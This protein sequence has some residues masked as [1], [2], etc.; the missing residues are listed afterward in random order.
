MVSINRH[1][2]G[3]FLAGWT[4]MAFAETTASSPNTHW[5]YIAP[6]RPDA[7]ETSH[8]DW[9]Q[10]PIDHFILARLDA[11]GLQPSPATD[12]ATW[13]RRVSLDLI[14]LPPTI[15]QL[16]TFLAD[17]SLNARERV[18]DRLLKS[19]QFGEHWA[20][21]WLDLARYGDSTGVHE[22]H[23]RPSWA[24]R[25]WVINALNAD[26]PFDQFTIE[27]IAGDLLPE[28]T[29]QQCIATGFH[30]AA[31]CNL[32]GG[33]PKEA[34][35]SAQVID[36]VIV[37]GTVWLG[38]T[39]E[40]AQCHDHKY[41]PFSQREFYQLYDYFNHTPDESGK[42]IGPG[43]SAQAGGILK[44]ANTRTF[45]ME[46]VSK[47]RTTRMFDRG[48]YEHPTET[49]K[50]GVPAIL[51]AFDDELPKN[52][53]GFAKWLVD[54]GNPLVARVT[55]NR[56]WSEIFGAGL[57]RTS[58]DFGTQ[59]E[60]PSH[61]QLLDWLAVEFMEQ[62]WSMKHV[63]KT[64]VLSATYAQ[65]S[66]LT[67]SRYTIDPDNRWL[68]RFPRIR[69][70]AEA[71]RDNAL[72][73]AGILSPAIGGPPAYPPQPAN[74]WWI[75]DDKSPKYIIDKGEQR[76]RR[77]IYTIWRRTYP[78]PTFAAFDAPERVTCTT[79]RSRTNTPLQALTL[80][81]D[82][83]Y[84]EASFALAR[85]L[86]DMGSD[87]SDRI[88]RGF[89]L[90][91]ARHAHADEVAALMNLY[92]S[93]LERFRSNGEAARKLLESVRGERAIGVSI[94]DTDAMSELAAWFHVANV[95]LNLDET[96]TKG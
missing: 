96:I 78:H 58:E 91:T 13:L 89:R 5:A 51:H 73:V 44:F 87:P 6:V 37:T 52:R 32:E 40:C 31:P 88:A 75:R 71:I 93:R 48:S 77:G 67:D 61:P 27:Q 29:L 47:R 8:P 38:T 24:W 4:T 7:P 62:G 43:R 19:K 1:I 59:G 28:P 34:R 12:Q 49:V 50:A 54:R 20:R 94:I 92:Q 65:S 68:A 36:R 2:L 80:L 18:V 46:E 66:N 56:W 45:V 33:T 60:R 39:L 10:S 3:L 25:D 72:S 21:Q 76:Y 53:L 81:N 85:R 23:V 74:L 55:V 79:Q 86:L 26:M 42:P 70:T 90:V 69:L 11:H 83:M 15:E 14:G 82:P 16:D 17:T 63:L 35:R 22:D 95:L 30:R 84:L 57:V 41:D 64:I 9:C